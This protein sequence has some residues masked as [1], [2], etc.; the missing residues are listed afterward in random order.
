MTKLWGKNHMCQSLQGWQCK[1]LFLQVAH[2]QK[3]LHLTRN[4]ANYGGQ[5]A[6]K[7]SSATCLIDNPIQEEAAESPR[8]KGRV[9]P[10]GTSSTPDVQSAHLRV[11]KARDV[12]S[13]ENLSIELNK[14]VME[15]SSL[16][17][18]V[19]EV[20]HHLDQPLE[21][22]P[23]LTLTDMSIADI[24]FDI[25]T[26]PEATLDPDPKCSNEKQN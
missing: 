17:N 3:N 10:S 23:S 21:R 11:E 16:A 18:G 7:N 14:H 12:N 22:L 26:E 15:N 4:Q 2:G 9:M 25:D 24:L 19:K 6:A 8:K 1:L 20:F 5:A 13:E